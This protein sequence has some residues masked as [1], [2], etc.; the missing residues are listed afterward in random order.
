MTQTPRHFRDTSRGI[1]AVAGKPQR[2]PLLPGAS[3]PC[4][5]PLDPVGKLSLR[6]T[7][8]GRSIYA[9]RIG[10]CWSGSGKS[11]A[12]CP[13]LLVPLSGTG[14]AGAPLRGPPRAT[15]MPV[16]EAGASH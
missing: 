6:A 10:N 14:G 4:P 12:G 15:L 9:G 16:T 2:H 11:R 1:N 13:G 8:L 3:G 5:S 7:S